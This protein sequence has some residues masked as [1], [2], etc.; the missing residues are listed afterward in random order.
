[1]C[2][3]VCV[4]VRVCACVCV[5]V[6]VC[7]CAC[8]RVVFVGSRSPIHTPT[9]TPTLC[10]SCGRAGADTETV[11]QRLH[12]IIK[13]RHAKR[14]QGPES[15]SILRPITSQLTQ[16][17]ASLTS[18]GT[19]QIKCVVVRGGA[20]WCVVVCGGVW[21]CV[22][23]CLACCLLA[24]LLDREGG[25]F[26]DDSCAALCTAGQ[27]MLRW[28][29]PAMAV[30]RKLCCAPASSNLLLIS[31]IYPRQARPQF[32]LLCLF[33]EVCV[34]VS[35]CVCVS[36]SLTHT[37]TQSLNPCPSPSLLSTTS[38][39]PS[40]ISLTPFHRTF[41]CCGDEKPVPEHAIQANVL[42]PQ[43]LQQQ[44]TQAAS[45]PLFGPAQLA[46]LPGCAALRLKTRRR[47]GRRRR[48]RTRTRTT[49]A[50]TRTTTTTTTTRRP[51][52]GWHDNHEQCT[53]LSMAKNRQ[54]CK[55]I[56]DFHNSPNQKKKAKRACA[57]SFAFVV[58]LLFVPHQSRRRG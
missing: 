41:E 22:V 5:C 48:R 7:V 46:Q 21:W 32:A 35:V 11:L 13:S 2:V 16:A 43:Y 28:W 40:T 52:L 29:R 18:A 42:V 1:M 57:H 25:G 53:Q 4:R 14:G 47:R 31:S 10:M 56:A 12:A 39:P 36:L 20:W 27:L 8:V 58:V 54:L 55:D 45:L 15:K 34:A 6:C 30:G 49:T 26:V 50:T 33:V 38:H 37:H 19:F 51:L 23:V 44:C 3:C 17:A 9:H 24:F